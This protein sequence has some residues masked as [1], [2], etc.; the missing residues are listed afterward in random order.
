MRE[1]RAKRQMAEGA[2]N[3]FEVRTNRPA[4]PS[5]GDLG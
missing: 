5:D 1:W 3:Q 4:A 2:G